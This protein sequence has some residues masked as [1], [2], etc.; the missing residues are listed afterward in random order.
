MVPLCLP[1]AGGGGALCRASTTCVLS[2][3]PSLW[4]GPLGPDVEGKQFGLERPCVSS[5][6]ALRSHALLSSS[7]FIVFLLELDQGP[8]LGPPD[9]KQCGPGAAVRFWWPPSAI[10]CMDPAYSSLVLALWMSTW[11]AG[12]A[13][14]PTASSQPPS[15]PC[16]ISTPPAPLLL[17]LFS[18]CRRPS[19][20]L[21]HGN[22]YV[23]NFVLWI[24]GKVTP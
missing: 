20:I 12:F 4:A 14:C 18:L 3:K 13:L 5:Q 21:I 15:Q 7:A 10:F 23:S 17:A 19:P 11:P 24:C 9:E 8:F 6:E 16:T 2:G 22:R 1:R